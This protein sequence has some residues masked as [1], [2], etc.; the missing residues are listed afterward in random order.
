MRGRDRDGM[1]RRRRAA[2][3][4][5]LAALA[6]VAAL[7]PAVDAKKKKGIGSVAS[8]AAPLPR[9]RRGAPRPRRPAARGRRTRR[10]EASRSRPTSRHP[11]PGCARCP[12]D[13]P[14]GGKGWTASAAAYTNPAASGALSS[15]VR[16]EKDTAGKIA[17]RTNSSLTLPRPPARTWSSTARRA[18]T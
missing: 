1:G 12:L 15:F 16:C 18:P 7:A 5:S 13:A 8:T 6:S 4:L 3:A 11:R 9:C 14:A 10:A 2:V 17:I